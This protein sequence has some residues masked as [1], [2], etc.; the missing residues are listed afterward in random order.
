MPTTTSNIA[1]GTLLDLVGQATQ[2]PPGAKGDSVFDA[3]L[4]RPAATEQPRAAERPASNASERD[5]SVPANSPKPDDHHNQT[6][7][8][9]RQ[10]DKAKEKSSDS[11]TQAAK[12]PREHDDESQATAGQDAANLVNAQQIAAAS[13]MQAP[14]AVVPAKAASGDEGGPTSTA[15]GVGDVKAGKGKS[16]QATSSGEQAPALDEAGPTTTKKGTKEQE[17]QAHDALKEQGQAQVQAAS[18]VP[19]HAHEQ[20]EAT[21]PA[22]DQNA[23]VPEGQAASDAV[24]K[25]T[26]QTTAHEEHGPRNESSGENN[27]SASEAAAL[28]AQAALD[29]PV[30]ASDAKTPPVVAASI[31]IQPAA[32]S[33]PLKGSEAAA[34]AISGAPPRRSRLPGELLAPAA[35]PAARRGHVEVDSAR[36]LNRVAR[37]LSAAQSR[38]GEIRLRLSPPELGSLKVEIRVQDGALVARLEAETDV[39][40]AA[41]VDNLPVLRERLAEQGVRI[42]R[43][44][45]DLMQRQTGG[46]ANHSDQRQTSEQPGALRVALPA[47]RGGEPVAA[48]AIPVRA[49]VPSPG[50]LNVIV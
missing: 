47:R 14:A 38:D 43:F 28:I 41:I 22:A 11:S 1:L 15:D 37:A 17:P 4:Q 50:G 35:V 32:D 46:F 34:N 7:P 9:A 45:V 24:S 3:L 19:L 42:E 26:V 48:A 39:A 31:P 29:Q 8:A 21:N 40:K 49:A 5:S 12:N 33:T 6:E 16:R 27:A 44:D 13:A 2:P 30:A 10:G 23:V 18:A 20:V 25:L 36:L